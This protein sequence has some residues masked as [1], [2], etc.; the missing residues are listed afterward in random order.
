MMKYAPDQWPRVYVRNRTDSQGRPGVWLMTGP[1]KGI[2][3]HGDRIETQPPRYDE[4]QLRKWAIEGGWDNFE[5]I[6]HREA[7]PILENDYPEIVQWLRRYAY[8]EPEL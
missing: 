8:D 5:Q 4:V 1:Q 7:I 2:F 3:C 6:S